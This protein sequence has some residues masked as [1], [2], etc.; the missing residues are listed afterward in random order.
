MRDGAGRPARKLD[1][2]PMLAGIGNAGGQS[3]ATN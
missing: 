1:P 2:I 3:V